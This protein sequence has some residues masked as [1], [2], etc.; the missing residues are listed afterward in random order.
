MIYLTR[1]E[2]YVCLSKCDILYMIDKC[3]YEFN[4]NSRI[5]IPSVNFLKEFFLKSAE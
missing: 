2:W 5:C 1:N 3:K 4:F